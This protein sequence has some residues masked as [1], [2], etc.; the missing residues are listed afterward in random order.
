MD[1][2]LKIQILRDIERY[3]NDKS[4]FKNLVENMK[5]ITKWLEEKSK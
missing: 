3:K 4:S 5:E 2:N 1:E